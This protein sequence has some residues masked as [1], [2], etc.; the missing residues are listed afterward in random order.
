MSSA[1][2]SSV[3]AHRPV[4]LQDA[5]AMLVTDPQAVYVDATYGRGGHARAIL[6]E[7]G[8]AGRLIA[9]DR[10]PDAAIDA[11]SVTDARFEFVRSRFSRLGDVLDARSIPRIAG[12]L[13]DLGVSSPQLDDA[14]RGFSLRLDGPLDMRMDPDSGPSVAQW[15]ARAD[16]TEVRRVLREYGDERFAAS[17]AKAIVARQSAGRPMER[18]SELAQVVARAIPI[19]DRKDPDQHPATRTFQAL[20]IFINQELEELA[21]TLQ[22]SVVRMAPGARLVVVSF[23]SLEDRIVKRFIESHSRPER[24]LG[25]LP[26]RASEL[27]PPRLRALARVR[28]DAAE[29]AANPRSRSALMRVAERTAAP[30]PAAA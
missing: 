9:L 30:V 15:L 2:P 3:A 28:P 24:A 22:A 18:T 1:F 13:M 8:P 21:L 7:L 23:H 26:L 29:I 6:R 20:R 16:Q 5:V 11:A 19:K 10:D 14:A 27:P 12:L 4:M 17:I 25:R